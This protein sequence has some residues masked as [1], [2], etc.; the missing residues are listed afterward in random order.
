MEVHGVVTTATGAS[1]RFPIRLGQKSRPLLLLW[2]VR[3]ENAFIEIDGGELV[4][5]FGYFRL[6]TPLTNVV[7]WQIEGPWRWLTAIGVRRGLRRGDIT[8]A[9]THTGGV[10]LDFRERVR[11][12]PFRVPRLYVSVDDLEGFTRALTERFG[13]PGGD[14]RRRP[15]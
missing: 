11:W 7:R 9:G 12:G 14:A 1:L 3:D 4:A 15:R 2:G 6:A 8:F 10:R 13:I 5:H